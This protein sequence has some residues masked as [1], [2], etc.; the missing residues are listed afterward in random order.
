[1]MGISARKTRRRVTGRA[2]LLQY[3]RLGDAVVVHLERVREHQR[4]SCRWDRLVLTDDVLDAH[5]LG[6]AEG[7]PTRDAQHRSPRALVQWQEEIG[8]VLVSHQQ[9]GI[10]H[11]L[12]GAVV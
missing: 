1:M 12:A 3:A 9:R 2:G 5:S 10:R 4:R 7:E 6:L 8:G 11:V